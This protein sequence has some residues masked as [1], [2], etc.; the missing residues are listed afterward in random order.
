MSDPVTLLQVAKEGLHNGPTSA[1]HTRPGKR[2]DCDRCS[3]TNLSESV[4]LAKIDL[5]LKC[6]DVLLRFGAEKEEVLENQKARK[7]SSFKEPEPQFRT[8]MEQSIFRR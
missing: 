8:F 1:R 3:R 5:C 2:I 6:V 4:G 7:R